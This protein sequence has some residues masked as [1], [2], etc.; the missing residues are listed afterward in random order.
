MDEKMLNNKSTGDDKYRALFMASRDAVMTL[1]PP[2]WR[3]T[4]GNPATLKMFKAKDEAEFLSYE[5]WKL[6]PKIQA[7][8]RPSD[9]KAK[10]MIEKAM[11]EGV[12]FFEWTHKRVD[13]EEFFAEVLLSKVEQAG[14]TF[15]YASVRDITER[16]KVHDSLEQLNRAMVG[17]ELR[18]QELKQ[19]IAEL[20]NN[21]AEKDN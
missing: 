21:L 4:S 6:S 3:F 15:L 9:E 17:R 12:N 8:G 13:G 7:D 5:P 19:E 14:K 18:M 11:K 1:E 10:E 2:S 16:K 20:K